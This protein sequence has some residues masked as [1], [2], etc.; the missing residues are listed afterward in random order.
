MLRDVR[1]ATRAR[2]RLYAAIVSSRQSA[3]VCE[4]VTCA[5]LRVTTHHG[6]PSATHAFA[7]A[8]MRRRRVRCP[9]SDSV[10]GRDGAA[11]AA[12]SRDGGG[13]ALGRV[14]GGSERL[15]GRA[16]SAHLF[17]PSQ[18]SPTSPAYSCGPGVLTQSIASDRVPDCSFSPQAYV[19]RV[20]CRSGVWNQPTT[21]GRFPDCSYPSQVL[22]RRRTRAP[23]RPDSIKRLG[24]GP[25][26]FLYYAGLHHPRTRAV[27]AS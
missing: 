8:H 27:R 5:P 14:I 23:R 22:P 21:S 11:D 9:P 12:A 10:D 16:H 26:P 19:T 4:T 18:Y 3:L 17:Y 15:L 6:H 2:E 7:D 24:L 20:Q 1:R 25:S 13:C